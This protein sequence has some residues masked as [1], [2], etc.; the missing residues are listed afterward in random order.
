MHYVTCHSFHFFVYPRH[1]TQ[2]LKS[3]IVYVF[4]EIINILDSLSMQTFFLKVCII[5]ITMSLASFFE[6]QSLV[7][8]IIKCFILYI[9][10]PIFFTPK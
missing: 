10:C 6:R 4:Y 7:C 2:L 9:N 3:N 5:K 1:S 8:F